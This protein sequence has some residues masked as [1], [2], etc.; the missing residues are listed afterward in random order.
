VPLHADHPPVRVIAF[1]TFD[2]AVVRS[3]TDAHGLTETVHRLV[4]DGVHA[5]RLRAKNGCQM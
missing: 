5:E 3:R 4:M 2:G 1:D